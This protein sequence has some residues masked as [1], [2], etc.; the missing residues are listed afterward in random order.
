MPF[1]G[2]NANGANFQKIRPMHKN[3]AVN[4]HLIMINWAERLFFFLVV[5]LTMFSCIYT[6]AQN[7]FK[8]ASKIDFL[9]LKYPGVSGPR[10][11]QVLVKSGK[12]DRVYPSDPAFL[13][14]KV[15]LTS[16]GNTTTEGF[17]LPADLYYIQSGFFCKREWELEKM[18]HIP[19]RFRLGSLAD[20]NA[21]E[22]KH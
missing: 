11:G 3:R 13:G 4:L 17:N 6:Q 8:M 7:S 20:C 10:T 15:L 16:F 9:Q 19:F 2:V 21:M 22:G 18:T 14:S 1:S 12:Y 5:W